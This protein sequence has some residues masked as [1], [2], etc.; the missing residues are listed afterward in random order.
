MSISSNDMS[1][2]NE[3]EVKIKE[4]ITQFFPHNYGVMVTGSI[5]TEYFNSESDIDIII[6]SNLY[7]NAFIE[8]YS[9]E[10][11]KMQAIVLPMYDLFDLINRDMNLGG[12]VYVHQLYHGKIL[13]DPFGLLK[14][15]KVRTKYLYAR[16]PR[17]MSRH[18]F[19]QMR[20]RIT[21]RVE[22]MLGSNDLNEQLLTV[23]DLYPR[24]IELFFQE[25]NYWSFQ[26]KSAAREI[27]NMDAKFLSDMTS[28]LKILAT[29]GDKQPALK[30]AIDFLN[31]IGGETHYYSTREY[32]EVC[33]SDTLVIYIADN[34]IPYLHQVTA[35]V[36][37]KF[38]QTM[39][40]SFN[41]LSMIAYYNP[42]GRIY[43]S[44]LYIIC[45]YPNIKINEEILP[46]VEMFHMNLYYTSF[47]EI[48]KNFTYP[49]LINPLDIFG[50]SNVQRE[51][52]RILSRIQREC[53]S[54]KNGKLKFCYSLF[55]ALKTIGLFNDNDDL[56]E[57]FWNI[58]YD[59][60][61]KNGNYQ[62]LPESIFRGLSM[63]LKKEFKERCAEIKLDKG[64][65]AFDYSH[66]IKSLEML[67]SSYDAFIQI[68][69]MKNISSVKTQN[70]IAFYIHFL[71]AT[72]N[73]VDLEDRLFLSYY[74]ANENIT[75]E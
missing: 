28:S 9:F 22:D 38:K 74:I 51:L 62:N 11:I 19:N 24:I 57:E 14:D 71:D 59:V 20:S 53:P 16:G 65:F 6:L 49:Y 47:A 34:G 27:K 60:F 3:Y 13:R 61:E 18:Q 7:R 29:S 31:K 68:V 39:Q 32:H 69:N 63:Q 2:F 4:F 35:S 55:S 10:G 58:V 30:F 23:L 37:E 36:W 21:S 64:S 46:M 66:E 44:G 17:K 40:K 5:L 48:A 12:S 54:D 56:W 43:R 72:S 70:Q 52:I 73:I 42:D 1:H 33:N 45:H 15:L 50:D 25:N 41:N 26:G 75:N 67:A 8:S